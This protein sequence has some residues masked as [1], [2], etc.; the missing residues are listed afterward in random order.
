MYRIKSTLPQLKWYLPNN[1]NTTLCMRSKTH[2]KTSKT[3][4]ANI[5]LGRVI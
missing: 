4:G 1:Y 2:S 5:R 3:I